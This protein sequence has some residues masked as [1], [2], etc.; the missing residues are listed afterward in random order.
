MAASVGLSALLWHL[1]QGL[2][3]SRACCS[4][5]KPSTTASFDPFTAFDS[6]PLSFLETLQFLG[7]SWFSSHLSGFT[8]SAPL[9]SSF[10]SGSSLFA[11][12]PQG[13]VLVY[14]S[15][16]N[17][18]KWV[19]SGSWTPKW[20]CKFCERVRWSITI[21]TLNSQSCLWFKEKQ[22]AETHFMIRAQSQT[23][24]ILRLGSKG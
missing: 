16:L 1:P 5:L 21:T 22:K 23:S 14:C 3:S 19:S 24:W 10:I 15:T 11:V 18:A 7:F 13:F 2:S 20:G 6:A 12:V 8:V 9:S 4:A 17:I